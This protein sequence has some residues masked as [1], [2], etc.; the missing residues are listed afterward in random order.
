LPV[1]AS[2]GPAPRFSLLNYFIAVRGSFAH[3]FSGFMGNA[4][5][6]AGWSAIECLQMK[7]RLEPE[8][9]MTIA[10]RLSPTAEIKLRVLAAQRGQDVAGVA[11]ELLEKQLQAPTAD[12]ALAAFRQQ[13]AASGLSD[14]ELNAFFQEVREEVWQQKHHPTP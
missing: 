5:G 12:D 8:K 11:A 9:N 13:V 6:A 10:I 14:E 7:P 4:I 1:P 3:P 2:L